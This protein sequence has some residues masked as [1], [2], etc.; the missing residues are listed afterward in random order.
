MF[1]RLSSFWDSSSL[2]VDIF[3][4]H[5]M[6]RIRT[7]GSPPKMIASQP[8]DAIPVHTSDCALTTRARISLYLGGCGESYHR[9]VMEAYS[10][11]QTLPAAVAEAATVPELGKVVFRQVARVV[12]HDG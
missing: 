8:G 9:M 5:P 10:V 7:V 6:E 3:E 1:L 2:R 4:A 11:S 12:S